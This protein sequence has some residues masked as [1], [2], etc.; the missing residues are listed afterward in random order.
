MKATTDI[1]PKDRFKVGQKV[2]WQAIERYSSSG[3][4]TVTKVGRQWV[5]LSN[6]IRVDATGQGENTGRGYGVWGHAYQTKEEWEEVH[7]LSTTWEDL[8][9]RARNLPL[10]RPKHVT[11]IRMNAAIFALNQLQEPEG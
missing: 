6:G 11:L 4:V 10:D 1:K 7:R 9:R 2:W 3:F 8:K 5:S